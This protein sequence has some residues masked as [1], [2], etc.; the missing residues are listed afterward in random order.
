MSKWA[1][2]SCNI[3]LTLL[4]DL[5]EATSNGEAVLVVAEDRL[6]PGA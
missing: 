4:K 2:V 5:E 6:V 1:D 3:V